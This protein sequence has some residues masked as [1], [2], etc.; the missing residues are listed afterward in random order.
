MLL[1]KHFSLSF[2]YTPHPV[3]FPA[4]G[5]YFEKLIPLFS[6]VSDGLLVRGACTRQQTDVVGSDPLCLKATCSAPS[7]LFFEEGGGAHERLSHASDV[8]AEAADDKLNCSA[9]GLFQPRSWASE[10][11]GIRASNPVVARHCS[12]GK[13]VGQPR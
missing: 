8:A 10:R 3:C 5:R 13:M 4:G 2:Q 7:N 6:V 11:L 12:T 9:R 1:D